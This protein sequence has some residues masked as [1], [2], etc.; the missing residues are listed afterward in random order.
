MM[1][2]GL[3]MAQTSRDFGEF[4]RRSL[5]EAAASVTVGDDGLDKIWIRIARARSSA[6][7]DDTRSRCEE[8]YQPDSFRW[9]VCPGAPR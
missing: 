7:T 9:L 5:N 8:E 3:S 6:A 4:L 1:P 2:G